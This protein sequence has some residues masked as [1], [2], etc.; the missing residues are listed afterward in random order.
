MNNIMKQIES[1]D[2]DAKSTLYEIFANDYQREFDVWTK[3]LFSSREWMDVDDMKQDIY[4]ESV[5]HHI[6]NHKYYNKNLSEDYLIK[7]S[8]RQT[9]SKYVKKQSYFMDK[10]HIAKEQ[11][12]GGNCIRVLSEKVSMDA[13]GND[14]SWIKKLKGECKQDPLAERIPDPNLE[15]PL[16]KLIY[17]EFVKIMLEKV[18][19]Y[20]SNYSYD[21][22]KI[23]ILLLEGENSTNICRIMGITS[24]KKLSN[25]IN[26]LKNI[27]TNVFH[28]LALSVI[29]EER[30][31]EKYWDVLSKKAKTLFFTQKNT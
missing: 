27:K 26:Y 6:Y 29:D 9:I 21:L 8:I 1:G 10:P 2:V 16:D 24:T 4:M 7:K 23:L 31:T 13:G 25:A 17:E 19:D 15:N 30:Y 28:P 5:E 14:P 11:E 12:K 22:G 18:K 20:Q 3:N